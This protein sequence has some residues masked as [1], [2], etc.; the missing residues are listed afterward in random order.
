MTPHHPGVGDLLARLERLLDDPASAQR[1]ASAWSIVTT[2]AAL[3]DSYAVLDYALENEFVEP[4]P[5][6]ADGPDLIW[7]NPIDGTEMVWIPPGRFFVGKDG[8][9]STCPG[10][11][12]A[13]HPVTNGQYERFLTATG[14]V[15]D[16]DPPCPQADYGNGRFLEHWV[17]GR[18]PAKKGDHPVVSVSFH[19][20][21]AYCRW[22]GTSLPG[23]YQWEKAARGTDGRTYPWGESVPTRRNGPAHIVS[24]GTCPVGT[25]AGV[26]GPYG[27]EGMIG[28]VSEWCQPGDPN[29]PGTVPPFHPSTPSPDDTASVRG[30]AYPFGVDTTRAFH[31]RKLWS[32]RRNSWVGFRP[33]V[34]LSCRPVVPPG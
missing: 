32:H 30:S 21:L 33:S 18:P 29:R 34:P 8:T 4:L 16:P 28:N 5:P 6:D 11:S 10:F 9:P 7:V 25:P 12:L 2:G 14:Y 15:P 17:D 20:A 27:C 23:E 13:R 22:S 1:S 19:D 24:L 31:Q 3:P 26:R